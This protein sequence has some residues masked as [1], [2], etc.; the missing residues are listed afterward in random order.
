[1]L[2]WLPV[3]GC[4]RRRAAAPGPAGH[5]A[6]AAAGRLIARLTRGGMIEVLHTNYVRTARAKGLRERIVIVRA[7]R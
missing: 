4:E 7:T 1:M 6:G 3:G 5:R 2:D